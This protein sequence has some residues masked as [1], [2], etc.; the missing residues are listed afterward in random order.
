MGKRRLTE[1]L[2]LGLKK[3][4]EALKKAREAKKIN[5]S[6]PKKKRFILNR[7]LMGYSRSENK[8]IEELISNV[9]D[10]FSKMD[11]ERDEMAD[12]IVEKM[13]A[14]LDAKVDTK[15]DAILKIHS[16]AQ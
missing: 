11:T 9:K 2:R 6:V 16:E 12:K 10:I 3:A 5:Q 4:H 1:A 8:R 7:T 13:V 15:L 14:K